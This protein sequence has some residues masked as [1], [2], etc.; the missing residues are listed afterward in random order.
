MI[1]QTLLSA[2]IIS[3]F[4][5]PAAVLADHDSDDSSSKENTLTQV[6]EKRQ[7]IRSNVSE[8]REEL[9]SKIEDKKEE[10]KLKFQQKRTE[11]A[12]AIIE[13]QTKHADSLDSIIA[14]IQ[15]RL[16]TLKSQGKDTTAAQTEL[17]NAKS[18]LAGALISITN[19]T[20]ILNSIT[21]DN[22]AT[23][24][25]KLKQSIRDTHQKLVATQQTL[26]KSINEAKKISDPQEKDDT[27]RFKKEQ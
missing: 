3:T 22:I 21:V 9:K 1:R 7:E 18:S 27:E 19:S 15:T 13:R 16:D 4:I 14:R 20:D 10:I 6:Q 11:V 8:K 12:K 23:E 24:F 26:R 5:S 17:D 25:P 2:A